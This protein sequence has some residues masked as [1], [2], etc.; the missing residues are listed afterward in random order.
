[1]TQPNPYVAGNAITK[2]E[3]LYGRDELLAQ[4]QNDLA[5]DQARVIVLSGHRRIGKTSILRNLELHFKQSAYIPVFF[6]LMGEGGRSA[7]ETLV[8]LAQRSLRILDVGVSLQRPVTAGS[9]DWLEELEA[10]AYPRRFLFLLDEFDTLDRSSNLPGH[11]DEYAHFLRFLRKLTSRSPGCS[12]LLSMGIRPDDLSVAASALV[13]VASKRDVRFLDQTSAISLVK[14][15]EVVGGLCFESGVPEYLV[16]LSGRHPYLIQLVCHALWEALAGQTRVRMADVDK[17]LPSV[18]ARGEFGFNWIW[19]GLALS[20]RAVL[21][22]ITQSRSEFVQSDDVAD[23]LADERLNISRT[24]IKSA[25]TQLVDRD[26]LTEMSSTYRSSIELFRLWIERHKTVSELR[27]DQNR[28]TGASTRRAAENQYQ[29]GDLRRAKSLAQMA[30]AENAKDPE[31]LLLMSKILNDGGKVEEAVDFAERAY[32]YEGSKARFE[33][34]R[35]LMGNAQ[36]A[37]DENERLKH[38]NRLLG[39]IPEY[40]PAL[41]ARKSIWVKRASEAISKETLPEAVSAY[42]QAASN[43]IDDT[44]QKI[45]DKL[46]TMALSY[47]AHGQF[48]KA[49]TIYGALSSCDRYNPEYDKANKNLDF[50]E[51]MARSARM[52]SW[53][54]AWAMLFVLTAYAVFVQQ[55]PGSKSTSAYPSNNPAPTYY[56]R[57]SAYQAPFSHIPQIPVYNF[58][59]MQIPDFKPIQLPELKVLPRTP[60]LTD[61]QVLRSFDTVTHHESQP[62][63]SEAGPTEF[64]APN[65]EAYQLMPKGQRFL[66]HPIQDQEQ[67]Q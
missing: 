66:S 47:E 17:V 14:R 48:T 36:K 51:E 13:R 20:E 62:P 35:L 3:G 65:G 39:S 50:K 7:S 54:V 9:D 19:D 57:G 60:P 12:L 58:Q 18:F 30:L 2:P 1:M 52:R 34:I 26:L 40:E 32:T 27:E 37:D 64:L 16:D 55:T 46:M 15:G 67:K 23:F 8:D 49:R 10:L 5:I 42:C 29:H 28:G 45:A 59:P 63:K 33:F 43:G 11:A 25:L 41:A 22:A 21:C 31:A 38:Y 53:K 44:C 4:I 56:N 24:E 6:D 61:A